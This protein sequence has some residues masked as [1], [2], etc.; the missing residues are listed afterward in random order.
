MMPQSLNAEIIITSKMVE[1]LNAGELES[2]IAHEISHFY[3]QHSLY[4][5]IEKARTRTEYLN[6]LNLSRAAEISADRAGLLGSG[7]IENSLRAMLKISTGLSDEHISFNFSSYLDQLRELK[8][9]HGNSNLLYA[10]HPT[11]LNRMQALIWFSM[12]HEYNAFFKT[13]KKGIY[14]LKAVDKKINESIKKVTGNELDNS[15]KEIINKAL[16]WG[17]LSIYLADKKFS[18]V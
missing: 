3:Y 17:S 18:K 11:F 10:T 1:L 15:N 16:L 5:P 4:P 9:L 13:D 12:S 2:V 8:E 14:D 7:S 6:F